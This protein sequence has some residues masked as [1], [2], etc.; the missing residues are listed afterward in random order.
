M[1]LPPPTRDRIMRG[2]AVLTMCRASSLLIK[3]FQTYAMG[4]LLTCT[5]LQAPRT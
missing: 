2:A 1:A 3:S 5:G 4:C